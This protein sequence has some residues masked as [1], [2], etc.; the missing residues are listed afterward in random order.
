MRNTG[1][2]LKNEGISA[3]LWLNSS[4]PLFPEVDMANPAELIA[5]LQ[6]ESLD[7]LL[8]PLYGQD[9]GKLSEK[10]ARIQDLVGRF[11]TLYPDAGEVSLF[12][13]PGRTE[14]GGNHTD[15]NAGRVLAAAVD[16]DVLAVAA[17]NTG[18]VIE[19]YSEGYPKVVVDPSQLD[20]NPEERY[21][22]AALIR[23]T[24]ARFVAL[25]YRVGGFQACLTS[26]VPKGSGL[27]S[28]AAYEVM[29]GTILNHLYNDGK[30]DPVQI[31][32]IAQY[33]EN[34]YF[35]K[36]CGLM[37]QTTCSVGG[38][39]TI[40]FKDAV[41]PLV[42]KVD[43]DF[44]TS[45]YAL[46]IVETGGDHADLNEEYAA[47]AGE[48]KAVARALGGSVLR[49]VTLEQVTQS[50][51][52]LRRQVNDRAILRAFH[53][54]AD[55]QRVADQVAALEAG[56]FNKFLELVVE[57][58]LSSWTL[59]QNCYTT[60]KPGEQGIPLALH[61]SRLWLGK[62]GAWRVHGGGFAGTIQIFVPLESRDSFVAR[63]RAVFG[64]TACYPISIRVPG[65]IRVA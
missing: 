57:S 10:K 63:M 64:E 4:I 6:Q 28:S 17:M 13:T 44:S 16:L 38:F 60:R 35:G 3:G 23:G 55:N 61:M 50:L 62:R 36:P 33:A 30:I 9:S 65:S 2:E 12:S 40:D 29:V 11:Q 1:Q 48:M 46:V 41:K 27:S 8:I 34:E 52:Q 22:S 20:M 42:H 59:N 43:Y 56:D 25:G 19:L 15:H 39:V 24:C 14:V 51:P 45:G 32:M 37:D 5:A 31:A 18:E 58:G 26:D 21:T 54:Y 47:V 7:S 49:D 53:F